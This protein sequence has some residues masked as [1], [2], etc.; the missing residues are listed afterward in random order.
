LRAVTA[1]RRV[2]TAALACAAI[3]G[4]VACGEKTLDKGS[5][6]DQ[7]S[8]KLQDQGRPAPK[9]VECPDDMKAKKGESYTCKLTAPN[10]DELDVK[11][12]ML[13]DDGKFEFEVAA[14]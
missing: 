10:G 2:F 14:Q 1:A 7:I 11:L 12:T 6:E 9:S 8:E 4:L 3:G 13:D 5:A